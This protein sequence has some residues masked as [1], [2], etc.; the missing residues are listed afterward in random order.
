MYNTQPTTTHQRRQ[1]NISCSVHYH[2]RKQNFH[3]LSLTGIVD[4]HSRRANQRR[5]NPH[6]ESSATPHNELRI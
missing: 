6:T 5:S 2:F 1:Q 3:R 4:R